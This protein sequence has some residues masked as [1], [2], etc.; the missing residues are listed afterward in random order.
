MATI[1]SQ[2]KSSSLKGN[3]VISLRH[4]GPY[5]EVNETWAKLTA[6]AFDKGLSGSDVKAV[7]IC[8]DDPTKTPAERIRYDACLTINESKAKSFQLDEH[9]DEFTGIRL[10]SIPEVKTV[11]TTFQGD[12]AELCIAYTDALRVPGVRESTGPTYEVYRNNPLL[13]PKEDLITEI[14]FPVG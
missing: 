4:F 7:G 12:Y 10:E 5:Q 8:Y 14:H 9:R 6:L 2:F 3:K 13:T 1:E 11:A